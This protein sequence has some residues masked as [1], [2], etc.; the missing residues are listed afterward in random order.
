M[1]GQAEQLRGKLDR[2]LKEAAEVSAELQKIDGTQAEVPHYSQ[3]ETAA[4]ETGRRLSREIQQ[5]RIREIAIANSSQTACP[6]C[7][8]VHSVEHPKRTIQSIDGPVETMEP[9]A[10]CSRCRRDFFP[11]TPKTRAR[12]A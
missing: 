4:H 10:H 1:E 6:T 11:S 2:L 8:D 3:I 5:A 9:K 7:G 12:R